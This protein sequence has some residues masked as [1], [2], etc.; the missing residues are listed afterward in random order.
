MQLRVTGTLPSDII[1][2]VTDLE[3]WKRCVIHLEGAADSAGLDER[4]AHAQ[5][6]A[7]RIRA[8]ER[9]SEDALA[10][11]TRRSRDIRFRG[12]AIFL[13]HEG[14]RYL[15]TARHVLTDEESARNYY[16]SE[17]DRISGD[18]YPSLVDRW[19]FPIISASRA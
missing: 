13:E 1:F 16:G 5:A 9:P 18:S 12:T 2:N 7:E 8:D 15:V 3:R 17:L 10:E 14:R 6:L 19:I 11:L 4:M